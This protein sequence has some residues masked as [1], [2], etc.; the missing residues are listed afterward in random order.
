MIS[1]IVRL[2]LTGLAASICFVGCHTITGYVADDQQFLNRPHLMHRKPWIA[3]VTGILSG[4]VFVL[5]PLNGWLVRGWTGAI[6]LL[7]F[8]LSLC[9]PLVKTATTYRSSSTRASLIISNPFLQVPF[10]AA[11]L[12]MLLLVNY[13]LRS[14]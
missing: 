13:Y 4:I 2:V 7:L 8:W 6:A 9:N 10:G 3:N 11:L 12:S 14:T 1:D 5:V